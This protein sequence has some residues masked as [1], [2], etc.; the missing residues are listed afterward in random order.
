MKAVTKQMIL[1]LVLGTAMTVDA[2]ATI[3]VIDL[4]ALSQLLQQMNAWQQQL[5]GMQSQR[6]QLQQTNQALTGERGMA[7]LL[8]QSA[9]E[10][11]YLPTDLSQLGSLATGAGAGYA[12]LSNSIRVLSA[13]AGSLSAADIARLPAQSRDLLATAR[14]A[15]A[16]NQAVTSLA[17][18]RSSDRFSQLSTL[19]STIGATPDL[20][21]IAELQGRIA[22][23]QAML[24]NEAVKL[25]SYAYAADAQRGAIDAKTREEIVH[26]H[27]SFA[28]RFQP[29]PPAP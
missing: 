3:P 11:N 19:I 9:A 1:A 5:R 28:S 14:L 21:A 22:A 13:S 24:A 8:L 12:G 26:G 20:K 25:Q 10:R 17:Y 2:N 18:S 7:Q 16:E 15:A 4:A 23:E 6:T 29:T 27:G